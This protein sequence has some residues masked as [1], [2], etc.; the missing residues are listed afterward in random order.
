MDFLLS[1]EQLALQETARR[2][3]Q[4]EIAPV[5]A[6]HDQTGEFPMDVM[7]KAWELGLSSESIP[8]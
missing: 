8:A 7:K 3:A 1:D 6:H 2:F 4:T 5:A